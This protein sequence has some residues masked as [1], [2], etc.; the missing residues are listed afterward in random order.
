MTS[1]LI[2]GNSIFTN[3]FQCLNLPIYV[4]MVQKSYKKEAANYEFKCIVE[5][6][7]CGSTKQL[8]QNYIFTYIVSQV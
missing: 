8:P 5:V 3:A 2:E 1:R 6:L 4:C 7:L